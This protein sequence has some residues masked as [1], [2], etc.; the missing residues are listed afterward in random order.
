MGNDISKEGFDGP[1]EV[2]KGRDIASVATY[3]KSKDCKNVFVMMHSLQANLARLNLPYPEAVFEINFFRENPVP[4]Y[5]LAREL[6]PGK[7]R[8]TPTHSFVKLLHNR[9]LLQMCYTQNIDTLERMAGVPEKAVVEA[10]GS[11]ANQHCIECGSGYDQ[12]T[13]KDEILRGEVARCDECGGLVKPDIVFFGESLPPKFHNTIGLLRSADLLIVMGTS[14]K[15]HPFASLTQLVPESCPRVLVNMDPAGDIGSRP[16]D[17]VLLGKTDEIVRDLCKELGDDW[18]EE[19]EALWKETEKYTS[20]ETEAEKAAGE[21][22][23]QLQP[24]LTEEEKLKQEVEKL[25]EDIGESLRIGKVPTSDDDSGI[26][27]PEKE[28]ESPEAQAAREV[29]EAV[30]TQTVKPEDADESDKAE[31]NFASPTA[32]GDATE[33]KL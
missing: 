5:T 12:H 17:V 1:P 28:E 21:A 3:I 32:E 11:F 15:V 25:T 9:S 30:A 2:L 31:D 29:E 27:A 4:F 19:L 14:L 6:M 16:D 24:K 23:L 13:L 8:P 22:R 26:P 10:H 7:Y 18:L 20:Q 33:S